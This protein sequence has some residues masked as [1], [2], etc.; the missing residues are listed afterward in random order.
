MG[1]RALQ[2]LVVVL[3]IRW[4]HLW[5]QRCKSPSQK[6]SKKWWSR[7]RWVGRKSTRHLPCSSR[8]LCPHWLDNH[9]LTT[10]TVQCR[11]ITSTATKAKGMAC[12]WRRHRRSKATLDVTKSA[13]NQW[14]R[15]V[16]TIRE[17]ELVASKE[18]APLRSL[19]KHLPTRSIDIYIKRNT[20]KV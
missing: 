9:L 20:G 5:S 3:L 18:S 19:T 8:S 6:H 11:P 12:H 10:S 16:L 15:K 2:W 17:Y 14:H 13:L 7:G 1:R 4:N